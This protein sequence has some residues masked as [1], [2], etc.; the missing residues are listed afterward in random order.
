MKTSRSNWELKGNGH[1]ERNAPLLEVILKA[2][3]SNLCDKRSVGYFKSCCMN[4]NKNGSTGIYCRINIIFKVLVQIVRLVLFYINS[5]EPADKVLS[6][7][8]YIWLF[9]TANENVTVFSLFPN[10]NMWN[11]NKIIRQSTLFSVLNVNSGCVW[12]RSVITARLRFNYYG[13]K[14]SL[15]TRRWQEMCGGVEETRPQTVEERRD[16]D[17][18]GGE[19]RGQP[20]SWQT[21]RTSGAEQLTGARLSPDATLLRSG[22]I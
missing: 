20:P 12:R 8:A 4:T 16:T 2:I 6:P 21:A 11:I 1:L 18:E 19:R 5:Q 22:W 13:S 9:Q 17:W 15:M 7:T 10:R 14:C 3:H